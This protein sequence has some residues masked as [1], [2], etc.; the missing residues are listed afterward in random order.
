MPS[1]S[2]H[3]SRL[4]FVLG[5]TFAL[6]LRP[7]TADAQLET[8]VR[9]VGELADATRQPEPSRSNGT[10][11]AA[12]RME[13]ALVEWDRT[14]SALEVRV[15]RES[16]G[17]PDRRAYQLHVELGVAYRVRGRLA[18]AL[19]EFDA[20]IARQPSSSDLQVLRAL[21]LDAAGRSLEATPAFRAAWSLD[22]TNPVKAYYVAQRPG[23]ETAA[24]RAPARAF[25]ADTY[26]RLR[27]DAARPA[28]APFVTLGAIPDNLSRTPVIADNATAEG[29]ALLREG[30]YRDAAA[31]L[32]RTGQVAGRKAEDSPL[33]YFAQGQR[34][35][36]ANRV[37]EARR[38]YQAALAGAL[39]GR[40]VLSVAIA[41]LA[42]VEGDVA[43]AID[44]LTQ[45]VQVNPNDPNIHKE[46]ADAYAAEGRTDDAFCEL[47]AALLIDSRDAQAHAAIGQLYLDTGRDEDAVTAFTRALE[48]TPDRYETR[49]ALATAFTR[50]GRTAE[51][52]R[53][54]AMFEDIRRQKLEARR[55][56]MASDVERERAV[57]AGAPDQ[58]GGR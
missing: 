46:L 44:A 32:K 19:R 36:A 54:F 14:I 4:L 15:E 29:F 13:T 48:L 7:S 39:V 27:L 57:G 42:Q 16:A 52:A 58:R 12:I 2:V 24:E 34:D 33:T 28:A 45:A 30:Q 10:R 5:V 43:G 51:A 47:M 41:R 8:F 17:A 23:A 21:T 3:A 50:L 26:R 56:D 1:R 40:S 9:A 20:A 22:A 55:R 25:L 37:P 31:A 11:I 38:A 18:D 35:E 53:Q 49:Y 6:T